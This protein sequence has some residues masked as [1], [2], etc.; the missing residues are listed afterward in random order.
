MSNLYRTLLA[1]LLIATSAVAADREDRKK[2]EDRLQ[3][4]GQVMS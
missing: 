2:Q 4:A 1:V 3:N